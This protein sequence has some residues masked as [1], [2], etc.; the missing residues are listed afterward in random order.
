MRA[1]PF[2]KWVISHR[3]Q[4]QLLIPGLISLVAVVL[5]FFGNHYLQSMVA[6]GFFELPLSNGMRVSLTAILKVY[7]LLWIFA[8]AVRTLIVTPDFEVR[9]ICIAVGLGVIGAVLSWMDGNAF[10]MRLWSGVVATGDGGHTLAG[11]LSGGWFTLEFVVI[12]VLTLLVF[13]LIPIVHGGSRRPLI[14]VLAPNRWMIATV[15]LMYLFFRV[16]IGLQ[17]QGWGQVQGTEG[18]LGPDMSLFLVVNFQYMALLYMAELNYRS[19]VR[20]EAPEQT[21]RLRH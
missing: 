11:F 12:T 20:K 21:W 3:Y 4:A 6:P 10:I 9:L 15:V 1:S 5:Y 17:G 7:L 16:A 18:V 2:G 14:R 19:V 13:V 8:L